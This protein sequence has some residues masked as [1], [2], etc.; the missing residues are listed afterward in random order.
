MIYFIADTHFGHQNIL[1]FS[2]RPFANIVAHD[3]ALISNWNSVVKP[4]DDIYILGDL[5]MSNDGKKANKLLSQLNGKKYMIIGNHDKYLND[6]AFDKSL[7][8]WIKPYYELQYNHIKFVL[9]HYPILEWNGFYRDAFHLYGHVHNTKMDYFKK[10]LSKR[11]INVGVD[12]IGFT[13]I[14]IDEILR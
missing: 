2:N 8:V 14:S 11:A 6:P 3:K 5:M 10:T 4:N 7:F 1:K 13:P 12:L 9:F